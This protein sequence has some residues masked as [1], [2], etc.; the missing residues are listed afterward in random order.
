MTSVGHGES[1][2]LGLD[3]DD[4]LGVSLEP[5]NVDFDIEVTDAK[6]KGIVSMYL[7]VE[8]KNERTWR[9]WRPRA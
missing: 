4:R 8:Q 3:V 6:V 2:N 5:C 9:Q 7:V 1:V